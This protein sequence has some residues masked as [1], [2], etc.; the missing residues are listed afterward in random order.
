MFDSER[1]SADWKQFMIEHPDR[2][3]LALDNVWG[4]DWGQGYLAHMEAAA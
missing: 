2:F 4:E 1:L 3:V